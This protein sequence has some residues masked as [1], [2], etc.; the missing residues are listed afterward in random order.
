MNSTKPFDGRNFDSEFFLGVM[1][2][3]TEECIIFVDEI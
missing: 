2:T 3:E 1:L